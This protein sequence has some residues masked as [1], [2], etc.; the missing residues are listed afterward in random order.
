M[1]DYQNDQAIEQKQDE[2]VNNPQQQNNGG[3]I[4]WCIICIIAVILVIKYAGTAIGTTHKYT[5]TFSNE[6]YSSVTRT[7]KITSHGSKKSKEITDILKVKVSSY[8]KS[9]GLSDK[10]Y[11]KTGMLYYEK[12]INGNEYYRAEG[13]IDT[14]YYYIYNP[15]TDTWQG[16]DTVYK[17]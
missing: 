4:I 8:G 12:T 6:S 9:L 3:G 15:D 2:S 11:E 16:S 13:I 5:H 1:E 10:E 17:R 14:G 7:L